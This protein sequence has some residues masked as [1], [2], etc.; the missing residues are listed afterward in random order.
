MTTTASDTR[1]LQTEARNPRTEAMDS[2]SSEELARVLHAENFAPAEAVQ[3]AL[4][5]IARVIEAAAE[6]MA[7]GGRLIYVG[8]GTSGRIGVL[9]ASECPP[10]FG[11]P[12]GLVVGLIAGGD[13]AL[14]NS[15]E[16]AEDDPAAGAA[17]LRAIDVNEKDV[18]IGIAASGRTP[19]AIGALDA[20]R[21]AGAFTAAVVNVSP[22]RMADHAEVT[23]AAVTGPEPLTGSTRL[24]A[25]TAQ[26]MVLNL[27][28]TGVMVRLGKTY[29]NLMV[30]V[31]ATN[32]KL[33]DR[34]VRIVTA[35]A[36]AD[37]AEARGALEAAD[38][39]AKTAIVML[40]LGTGAAEAA[41]RLESAG[42]YVRRA[43]GEQVNHDV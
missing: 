38:W 8:A 7:G 17:D 43:I 18:V 24:R 21:A 32:H 37:A 26:K 20:A 10:T 29:G 28:S 19:Y 42:G 11:V 40:R 25:G 41:A 9:D 2:L 14:R 16:G 39:N 1:D 5:E 31:R 30:D 22:S 34:A 33:R 6:R 35:A 3:A 13:Y 23:I 15:I 4:P 12:P 27:I 36:D